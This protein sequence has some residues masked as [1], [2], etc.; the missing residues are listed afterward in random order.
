MVDRSSNKDSSC[1]CS[2]SVSEISEPPP[3]TQ[4]SSTGGADCCSNSCCEPEAAIDPAPQSNCC[5]TSNCCSPDAA[6]SDQAPFNPS[7]LQ[8]GRSFQVIGM[9]CAEEVAMLKSHVGPVVGGAEH[10]GF[11]LLN[12]RMIVLEGVKG[13]SDTSVID[14]I[15]KT[16]LSGS[17]WEDGA[18]SKERDQ[19]FSRLKLFTVGSAVAWMGG[20]VFHLFESKSGNILDMFTGHGS[21]PMPMLEIILYVIAAILGARFVAPKAVFAIRRLSPDMNLLMTIAILGAMIIGEFFEAATVAFLFALSLTLEAWSVGRARNAISSLLSLAPQ[22]ALK[23]EADGSERL[24]AANQIAIGDQFILR[25]GDRIP[26]DGVV[27][28][29]R[30]SVNQAPITGE[31]IPVA[32]EE[33]DEVFAGTINGD[34]SL[35]VRATKAAGDTVLSRIIT[36]VQDAHSKRADVEQWVEKFAKIYTPIVMVL[37]FLVFLLPPLLLGGVWS[38]WFYNALVLLVIACP[39]ALV[40]STPVAIVAALTAAA[41]H[42]VLVKGGGFM[43]L[44]ARLDA[45]ALDKTGTLTRGEPEV[46]SVIAFDPMANDQV[47]AIAASLEARSSHPLALAILAKAKSEN[48]SFEQPS[49]AEIS[50]GRGVSGTIEGMTY[51]LGSPRYAQEKELMTPATAEILSKLESQGQTAVFVGNDTALLGIISLADAIRDDAKD[52]I[53]ALHACGVKT[54]A[55]LTGD[56][57]Q[58]AQAVAKEVGIDKVYANLL[59]AQKVEAIEALMKEHEVVAM[60]GDGVNDAPA[61]ARASF[62]IAMGAVGSDA[63]I[64]TADMALMS[65]DIA[66]LPWMVG[67]SRRTLGIIKQNIVFSLIVKAIFVSLTLS[68]V[69]TMWGAIVADVG[70]SLLVVSNA[71]RLL[72]R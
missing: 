25:G 63:A 46:R 71:L 16:G 31:S 50:P 66:K 3:P 14:A 35:T 65:D 60:V 58:T 24:I 4:Q 10:L 59:P 19:Q 44:P 21:H 64:E 68:G 56:N 32:K 53:S 6:P 7:Q 27:L 69:A 22:Q 67:H 20:L 34:G 8:K 51:W 52:V 2:S 11:D 28:S 1:G 42:G 54:I 45:I 26:L 9:C 47:L 18:A 29:G 33:G 72:K 48:I 17:I 15:N 12:G 5:A 43:E 62:G 38:E 36:L 41:K 57:E 40:I 23:L 70:T 55:M 49:E 39:C 37:A 30:S 61:M 13:I